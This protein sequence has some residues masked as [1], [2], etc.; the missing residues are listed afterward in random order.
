YMDMYMKEY[1]SFICSIHQIKNSKQAID[2][3]VEMVGL[4][5]EQSKKIHQ[6]SKG[7]KQRVGLAQALI[8]DPD[9]L[10]LDEPTTGLDP[11]Q[12]SEIRD[13]I[14]ELGKSKVIVFSTHIM[15]EVQAVC[16]RV[17]IIQDGK[18]VADDTVRGLSQ[19][20]SGSNPVRF[21]LERVFNI[22]LL[23]AMDFITSVKKVGPSTYEMYGADSFRMKKA[24]FELAVQQD[25]AILE[26]GDISSNL[27]DTFKL[28]TK[29]NAG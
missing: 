9:I 7:Y 21:T 26:L 22:D 15:Q 4:G 5:K 29:S 6:L 13:L 11:N 28:L 23:K 19:R 27:E 8:H 14:K 17:V 10:I 3:V 12:L 2:R 18:I 25:N 1:L 20:I 16:D 24:L